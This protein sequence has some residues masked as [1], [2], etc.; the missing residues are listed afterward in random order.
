VVLG[1]ALLFLTGFAILTAGVVAEQ[2]LTGASV[3]AIAILVL[4][5]VGIIGAIGSQPRDPPR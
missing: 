4:L 1:V 2:G 3:I 5:G